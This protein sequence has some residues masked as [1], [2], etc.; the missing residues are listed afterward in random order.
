LKRIVCFLILGLLVTFGQNALGAGIGVATNSHLL[1]TGDT[2]LSGTVNVSGSSFMQWFFTV[3]QSDPMV[4]SLGIAMKFTVSGTGANGLHAGGGL[5]IG[6][7]AED[8]SF[9][10]LGGI[11]GFHFT[12]VRNVFI[13]LDAGL[14]IAKDELP[15]K[16]DEKS[17]I[18]IGGQSG[19]LGL[20][21][22]YLM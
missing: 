11:L 2:A 9:L 17:Q 14:T 16:D 20:S 18:S 22:V 4:Y 7:Y 19:L 1:K 6:E 21:A 3:P 5:G 10:R 13:S 12:V 8:L 15:V